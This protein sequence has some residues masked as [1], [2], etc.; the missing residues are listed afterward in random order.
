MKFLHLGDL[1]LGK[2]VYGYSMLD[3]QRFALEQ[4][5]RMAAQNRVDAVVIAGDIYDKTVPPGEAVSLFDWFFTQLC[6][7]NITVLAVSG[8]HDSGERLNFGK[9]L[10]SQQGMHL[11]GTF[12]GTVASVTLT[13]RAQCRVQF[14]LLPWLRPM[15]WREAM[16]LEQSTQQCVMDAMGAWHTACA[17][18]THVCD[19][20]RRDAGA[21][22]LGDCSGRR[23]RCGGCSAV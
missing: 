15:E 10:L 13:D 22:G 1:H 11:V 14:H 20:W 17:G 19:G 2:R 21:V 4:V 16:Q 7:R 23:R 5:V 18:C 8:N 9:T 6:E 3:D 12:D